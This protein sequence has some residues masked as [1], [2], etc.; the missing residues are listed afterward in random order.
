VSAPRRLPLLV[1]ALLSLC[2]SGAL[3]ACGDEPAPAEP[4]KDRL[5]AVSISGDV[6]DEPTVEWS[7]Q[8]TAGK[9][10][11]KT[12]VTGD[13]AEL[14]D[15]DQVLAHLWIG[16][17]F[18]EDKSFSTHD[19]DATAELVTVDDTLPP[20]LTALKGATIGS[21]IAVTSSA[22]E[23]FGPAGNSQLGIG[24]KDSVLVI[25]DL[26]SGIAPPPSGTRPPAPPWVPK[27]LFEKGVVAGFDFTGVPEPTDE[28]QTSVLFEGD[29][30]VVEKGKAIVASY[31]G[32]VYGQEKPF[33]DN[34]STKTPT[35]F[36]IGTGA[37]I[38]GWDQALV[39]LKVG[40]RVV[41]AVPPALGYGDEGN[42]DAGIKRTDTLYFVIDILAT[43]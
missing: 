40:T 41:L 15:G 9:I 33:D 4:T 8:M 5:D 23:A 7:S 30:A 37:V 26:A 38:K 34:F 19:K 25:V 17:G 6:G 11:S 20:F 39:G 1:P 3:V 16:N 31:L 13:G 36:A 18:T 12:L 42:K 24:N 10:E 29:G 35:S 2:L 28:L 14:A 43:A 32:E 22:E 27:I 21:R